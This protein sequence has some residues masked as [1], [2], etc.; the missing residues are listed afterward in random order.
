M[1]EVLI[2]FFK[3]CLSLETVWRAGMMA[4]CVFL[5]EQKAKLPIVCPVMKRAQR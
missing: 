5:S 3:C 4:L 2:S 1:K